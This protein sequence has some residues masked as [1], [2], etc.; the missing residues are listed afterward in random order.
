MNKKDTSLTGG[1][2]IAYSIIVLH[3]LVIA[4]LFMLII[5]FRGI[6][7]YILWIT[8][9]GIGFTILSGIYFLRRLKKNS[10][11]IKDI[12]SDPAFAGRTLEIG[13]FGG[14]A[15]LK[16]NPQPDHPIA[17]GYEPKKILPDNEIHSFDDPKRLDILL[18]QNLITRDEFDRL[19]SEIMKSKE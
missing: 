19:K 13:F 7:H 6:V 1:V 10:Q 11:K 17:L 18:E 14:A 16:V 12:L 5:F 3:A 8:L 9:A 4:L 15:V 2:L